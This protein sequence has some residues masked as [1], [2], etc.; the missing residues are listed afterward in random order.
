MWKHR[1][2]ILTPLSG[3]TSKQAKCKWNWSKECQ[4]AFDTI[5]KLVSRETLLSYPN[6]NKPFIIHMEAS[7]LL[8]GAAISQ[9][10]IPIAFYNRKLNST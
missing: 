4:K 10:D 6:F 3:M 7:K 5:K 9:D 8:L 2:G 1:S